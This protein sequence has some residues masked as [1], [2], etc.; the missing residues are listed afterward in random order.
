M[1]VRMFPPVA[2]TAET[3]TVNG[4]T[5]AATPGSFLDVP[6]MDATALG[7]SGWTRV[8]LS[9]PTISRPT[10]LTTSAPYIAGTGTQFYDTTIE[11]LVVFDGAA[12]RNPDTGGAV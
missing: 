11:K 10:T 8:A 9:G 7:A 2:A 3:I 5:Y 6:D 1:N 4:R 12:W